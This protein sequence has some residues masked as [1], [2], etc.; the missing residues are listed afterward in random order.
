ML[1]MFYGKRDTESSRRTAN[2]ADQLAFS[3]T[4][5]YL[6]GVELHSLTYFLKVSE[7][8]SIHSNQILRPS[9]NGAPDRSKLKKW[10]K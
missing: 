6:F 2:P 7:S 8:P 3:V 1:L 10:L 5:P 4:L 9:R